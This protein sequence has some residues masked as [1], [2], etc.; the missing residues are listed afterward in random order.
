MFMFFSSVVVI[1][2]LILLIL[3]LTLIILII[4]A[5][6]KYIR[7]KNNRNA[8][9]TGHV[10]EATDTADSSV[11]EKRPLCEILKNLRIQNNM[12]QE[13]VAESLGITRQAVSK[14]ETGESSPSMAN[15][16]ALAKLYNIPLEDILKG[17]EY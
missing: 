1:V 10:H 12:T 2:N 14:W 8:E 7:G 5:L 3:F 6:I 4:L 15:L 17:M 13:Y 11:H 9:Q 16:V